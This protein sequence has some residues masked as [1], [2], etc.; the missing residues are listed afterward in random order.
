MSRKYDKA[1]L[2][3]RLLIEEN[4]R[5][6][7]N[8]E[9]PLTM[10]K[11]IQKNQATPKEQRTGK[12][13]RRSNPKYRYNRP[14]TLNDRI[15][16]SDAA[17][18]AVNGISAAGIW[19]KEFMKTIDFKTIKSEGE[20]LTKQAGKVA[21]KGATQ[22]NQ[23]LQGPEMTNALQQTNDL[24]K[25]VI[26]GVMDG[27]KKLNTFMQDEKNQKML[28]QGGTAIVKA[29]EKATPAVRKQMEELMKKGNI[30]GLKKLVPDISFSAEEKQLFFKNFWMVMSSVRS[31][32]NYIWRF[33]GDS[34]IGFI[35]GLGE[36]FGEVIY[37]IGDAI[38][39]AIEKI[40]E[41]HGEYPEED[42]LDVKFKF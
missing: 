35:Q 40:L 24:S 4:A 39:D 41:E 18:G 22:I 25:T 23:F 16:L 8:K 36:G 12:L 10:K 11:F 15:L 42:L 14:L 5:R 2:L 9:K 7:A 21:G 34:V 29:Y 13:G 3:Q 1:K 37:A 20:E 27:V 19:T 38:G 6:I 26:D 32:G 17:N 30:E 31:V 28:Q 33:G